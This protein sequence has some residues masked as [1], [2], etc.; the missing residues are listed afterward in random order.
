MA[1]IFF[2]VS[3][4]LERKNRYKTFEAFGHGLSII[5]SRTEENRLRSREI[6]SN[7]VAVSV[8]VN[9]I[10]VM[11]PE[12]AVADDV[13]S[14]MPAPAQGTAPSDL[15]PA[16]TVKREKLNKLSSR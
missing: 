7:R 12:R 11:D 5:G 16:T 1:I 8:F 15:R 3:P 13:E 4:K 2:F 6:E 10:R 9:R 14:N